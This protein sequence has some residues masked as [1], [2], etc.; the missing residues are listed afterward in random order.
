MGKSSLSSELPPGEYGAFGSSML[1][2][3]SAETLA[4]IEQYLLLQLT[5]G[6]SLYTQYSHFCSLAIGAF[7]MASISNSSSL[8]LVECVLCLRFGLLGGVNVVLTRVLLEL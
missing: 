1:A 5:N 8:E 3:A 6:F 2:S 7:I 4:G